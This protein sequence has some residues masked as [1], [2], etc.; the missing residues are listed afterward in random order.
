MYNKLKNLNMIFLIL[1][2]NN[3][4][5]E[6]KKISKIQKLLLKDKIQTTL[7]YFENIFLLL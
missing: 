7:K 4:T 5:K 6:L 3:L 1:T 2:V